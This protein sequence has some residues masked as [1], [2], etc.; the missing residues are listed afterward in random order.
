MIQNRKKSSATL[1]LIKSMYTQMLKQFPKIDLSFQS[2][3]CL[4]ISP[5][6]IQKW[7]QYSVIRSSSQNIIMQQKFLEN[8][9]NNIKASSLLSDKQNILKT[10]VCTSLIG[11]PLQKSVYQILLLTF[12]HCKNLTTNSSKDENHPVSICSKI[13]NIFVMFI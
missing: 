11:Q 5:D 4:L 8:V 12:K 13:S 1:Y 2:Y 9:N 10:T 7:F 6:T 3:F